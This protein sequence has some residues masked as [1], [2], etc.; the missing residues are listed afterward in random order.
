[1]TQGRRSHQ[2]I[3]ASIKA[4]VAGMLMI[5]GAR[6]VAIEAP[7]TEINPKPVL[8]DSELIEAVG[9]QVLATEP[10]TGVAYARLT[11]DQQL[12]L[13]HLAHE[14]GSCAGFEALPEVSDNNLVITDVFGQ[15]A[16]QELRNRRF[17]PM[18]SA[19]NLTANPAIV[20][21]LQQI[22]ADQIRSH[23]EFLSRFES[24]DN[25]LPNANEP[26]EAFK[27]RIEQILSSTSLPYQVDLI[28]HSSTGQKSIRVHIPGSQRPN[29]IVALGGHVDS[30]N[31]EWFG[32]R[33]AP[34]ADDNASG[35]A[36]LLE[37]LRVFAA[38]GQQPQ[39]TVEFFWYAGEESG[40]LGSA[41]IAREYRSQNKDVVGVLQLDMTS[42][43][44]AGAGKIASMSDFTSAWMRSYFVGLNSTYLN[45]QILD[46]RCGYGCSDHASWHKQGYPALMPSEAPFRQMNKKLHTTRDVI[47]Q[48][49]SFEHA[50][51]FSKIA[52]A[53]A[54]DLGN[55]TA[56]QP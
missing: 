4:L 43:P 41:E 16:S 21:G 22:S 12:K 3:H 20:S 50:A 13:S 9:A 32:D 37:A 8:A 29:E 42:F 36:C 10:V 5:A 54:M 39:R 33:H 31:Q 2:G 19:Q 35:S 46:D 51:I 30:I 53:I 56:R 45:A 14:R 44:G 38:Q 48:D 40:L 27:A 17:R 11:T 18:T 49:T 6:A 25:R 1:M 24:R 52:L 26:I 47:D 55:S 15:L 7:R 28:S 23:V 34:G